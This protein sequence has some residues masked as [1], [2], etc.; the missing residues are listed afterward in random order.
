MTKAKHLV[1]PGI[2]LNNEH[3]DEDFFKR[4][5]EAAVVKTPHDHNVDPGAHHVTIAAPR[6]YWTAKQARW[7]VAIVDFACTPLNLDVLAGSI[8]AAPCA[9][10]VVTPGWPQGF[11]SRTHDK[12]F[13]A[14][15]RKMGA[16]R[17]SL[18]HTGISLKTGLE[19]NM[20]VV[21][22]HFR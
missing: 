8:F 15:S 1:T 21:G 19:W 13:E 18:I 10:W 17:L 12:A 14:P 9:G 5:L 20:L 11:D 22:D 7:F 2:A 6:S 16:P 3:E 4:A